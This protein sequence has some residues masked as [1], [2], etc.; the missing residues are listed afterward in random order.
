MINDLNESINDENTLT[1][2]E[3]A[4]SVDN[5][6]PDNRFKLT[7]TYNNDN[8]RKIHETIPRY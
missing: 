4:N 7:I 6:L 2:I 1:I 3:W 5:F 8:T